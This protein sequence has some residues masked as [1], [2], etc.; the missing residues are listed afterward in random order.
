ML[1]A[2]VSIARAEDLGE[3]RP[4]TRLGDRGRAVRNGRPTP[5]R[6]RTREVLVRA[7]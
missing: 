6:A 2:D 1:F 5:G 4:D 3:P 7:L